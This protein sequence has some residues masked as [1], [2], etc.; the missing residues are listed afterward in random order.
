MAS[1]VQFVKNAKI[2]LEKGDTSALDG[3]EQV[4]DKLSPTTC[5][6]LLELSSYYCDAKAVRR[7]YRIFGSFEFANNALALAIMAGN[8]DVAR[9]L[10]KHKT[11]LESSFEF[12][13]LKRGKFGVVGDT[14]DKREKR[15][16]KYYAFAF[17]GYHYQK[18]WSLSYHL[19]HSSFDGI[20]YLTLFGTTN[21]YAA[22]NPS[23]REVKL[24]CTQE[25]IPDATWDIGVVADTIEAL[26]GSGSLNGTQIASCALAAAFYGHFDVARRL[27]CLVGTPLPDVS[28]S[29]RRGQG[30]PIATIVRPPDLLYPG[31]SLGMLEFVEGVSGESEFERWA[32]DGWRPAFCEHDPAVLEALVPRLNPSIRDLTG[33]ISTCVTIG[34]TKALEVIF[35][36]DGVATRRRLSSCIDLAQASENVEMVAWLL[37]KYREMF[38]G[39]APNIEI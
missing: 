22:N 24:P 11:S 33:L 6:E 14:Y 8:A 12:V 13:P 25:C 29:V 1:A 21:R 16:A 39:E 19:H 36:W 4:A 28:I 30:N 38:E 2:G 5:V 23:P 27:S 10:I 15:F 20:Y 18:G 35:T 37:D 3:I 7:L 26:A 17:R 31:C 9:V 34:S 32:E